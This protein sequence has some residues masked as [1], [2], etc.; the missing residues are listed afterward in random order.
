MCIR[1]RIYAIQATSVANALLLF[2]AAPFFAAVL[3]WCILGERVLTGTWIAISFAIL[4][5]GIMVGGQSFGG[6]L[7]GSLA[8]LGSALGFAAFTVTLRWGKN[9]EMLPSVFLSGI[10]GVVITAAICI[11]VDL[12]LAIS[13]RDSGIS[14]GMGVFQV[15]AGLVLYTL[16]SRWLP[17]VEQTVVS[18]AEV[19]LPRGGGGLLVGV[20]W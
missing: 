19:L 12:P 2:A 15:G 9:V 20:L 4:G 16:G 6:S 13:A 8:A 14:I 18:E 1:D 7:D 10:F 5:I 11:S 17:A 3:G